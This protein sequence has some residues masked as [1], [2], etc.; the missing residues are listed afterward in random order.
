MSSYY[1]TEKEREKN[2]R[3]TMLME[4]IAANPKPEINIMWPFG[5][6]SPK[7]S[8]LP[9]EERPNQMVA[10]HVEGL[11]YIVATTDASFIDEKLN[12]ANAEFI[13]R[14]CN[15][16]YQ[17]LEALKNIFNT[18]GTINFSSHKQMREAIEG[19]LELAE[20]ALQKVEGK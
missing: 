13:V 7:H 3:L 5:K 17:L 2:K 18:C 9:W 1:N 14:A 16:H 8:L 19:A 6:N 10:C 20:S 15:N 4:E 12:Q 11:D